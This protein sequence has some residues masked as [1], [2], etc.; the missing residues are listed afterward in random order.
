MERAALQSYVNCGYTVTVYTYNPMDEFMAH[1]PASPF[2]KV[3]DAREI[4][5]ESQL[6][7]YS[8]RTAF[9]KRENAYSY[10]PFSDLFRF[11]ML[12]RNGGA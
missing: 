3:H 5:P 1:V 6:F 4:L 7:Q 11:T 9:G 8:G 10:L 12:H 2:I